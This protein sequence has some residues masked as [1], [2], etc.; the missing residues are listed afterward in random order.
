MKIKKTI[1][2]CIRSSFC[3]RVNEGNKTH[4]IAVDPAVL[5]SSAI[6]SNL[7][8]LKK[9]ELMLCGSKIGLLSHRV[10]KSTLQY[11]HG[12]KVYIL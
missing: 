3:L 11:L 5:L 7:K 9:S 2:T 10:I 8:E 4:Y 12:N 1:F 6:V